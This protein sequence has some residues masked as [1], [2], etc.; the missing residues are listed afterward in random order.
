MGVKRK[1][2]SD[3]STMIYKIGF[4]VVFSLLAIVGTVVGLFN[5]RSDLGFF[6][7]FWPAMMAWLMWFASRLKWV[8]VDEG[9]IYVAGL[10]TEVQIPLS[11]VDTVESSSMWRPKQITLRLK[12][13]SPFGKKIVF[14]PPQR[15]FESLRAG[16]PLVDELTAIVK[17]RTEV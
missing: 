5:I 10:R 9:T 7:I 17:A 12:S 8:S 4:P 6:A 2:S 1:L 14:V 3:D 16:H 15:P 13:P 11:E